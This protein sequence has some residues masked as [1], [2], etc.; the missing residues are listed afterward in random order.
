MYGDTL[1]SPQLRHE[2]PLLIPDPFLYAERDGVR[3]IQ[4]GPLEIPRLAELGLFELHTGAEFGRRELVA[5]GVPLA[6][7]REEIVL[8]AV[9]ALGITSAL[10]PE[11]FPMRM[12]D[13]LRAGGVEL[14]SDRDFFVERMRCKSD[15]ELAGITR[16]QRAAEEGM[17]EVRSLLRR[18]MPG[19]DGLEINGEPLTVER[20]KAAIAHVFL[21][22]GASA[23]AFIVS[24]GEQTA[25]GHHMGAG[26]L[27]PGEPI[28][29][30]LWPRDNKSGCYT[31][32]TRTFVVGNRPPEVAEWHRLVQLALTEALS[33]IRD[34]VTG[35]AIYDLVCDV[36]EAAG[37]STGRTERSEEQIAGFHLGL[38]HGVGLQIH[39]P[40]GLG[41]AATATLRTGDVIAVEPGL[42]RAGIGGVRLE[43]LVLVTQSGAQRFTQYPYDLT[44]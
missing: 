17:N 23:E 9:K 30:D 16:A 8:R 26:Q 33:H 20:I 19:A 22:A 36:F 6:E 1:R 10:V 37:Y 41:M 7:V 18:A 27:R 43:D 44:P 15:S 40:P 34:G 31:D 12:A 5:A 4:I 14:V 28:I 39:E 25:A 3:H 2:V 32:M 11:S 24:H 38:G 29:V 13:R 21:D 42:Y 35:R